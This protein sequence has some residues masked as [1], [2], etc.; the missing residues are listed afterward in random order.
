MHFRAVQPHGGVGDNA[1]ELKLQRL[2]LVGGVQFEAAPVPGEPARTVALGKVGVFVERPLHGPIM[3]QGNFAP[4]RVI[5]SR[6]RRAAGGSGLRIGIGSAVA[7]DYGERD[8]TGVKTPTGV[9]RE[10]CRPGFR[11]RRNS[12]GRIAKKRHGDK[13]SG[14][15]ERRERMVHMW[16]DSGGGRRCFNQAPSAAQACSP[17]WISAPAGW[18]SALGLLGFCRSLT[19]GLALFQA[20]RR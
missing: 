4:A 13:Q 16:E 14:R 1:V 5:K 17:W 9:K 10:S 8:I 19:D 15:Q 20:G 7:F 18:L 12:G 6:C 3:R 11:S 2:S